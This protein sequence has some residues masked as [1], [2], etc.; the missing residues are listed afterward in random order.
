MNKTR[1]DWLLSAVELMKSLFKQHG[2][3]IPEIRVSCGWPSTKATAAKNRRIGECWSREA[4]TDKTCQIFISPYLID[5]GSEQGVI[6]TLIHEVCHAVVGVNH[7]HDKVFGKCARAVG[8]EGKLTSTIAGKALLEQTKVWLKSLGKYPHAR[9]DSF[10][11]PVKKQ[12]T[13]MV[14]CECDACG[15][16]VRTSRKWIDDAGAPI[17]PCNKRA[18]KFTIPDELQ[19]EDDSDEGCVI[20]GCAEADD[21]APVICSTGRLLNESAIRKHALECSKRFRAG[22]Y[23][24][25]GEEFLNEVI[26]DVESLVREL[27]A[28][29]SNTVHPAMP[30]ESNF[31]TGALMDKIA[32]E[33]NNT[34]GRLVQNKVQKQT[35]GKTLT[36]TR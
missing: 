35:V 8:L 34:I 4:A 1:E 32:E 13:R 17:C 12:T 3:D 22:K 21:T 20:A 18:M 31:V 6:S 2:Y 29:Y 19:S 36:R 28:R 25:V 10:K 16:T 15:Y 9:L 33:L 11:S 14:K 23:T 30:P 7:K 5:A 24:R 26:A 27:R